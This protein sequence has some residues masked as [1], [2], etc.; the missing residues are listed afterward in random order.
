MVSENSLKKIAKKNELS[1]KFSGVCFSG[2]V[3]PEKVRT[4]VRTSSNKLRTK[5]EQTLNKVQ[6]NFKQSL[7]KLQTKFE[8]TLNFV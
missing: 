3:S 6:T 7:N 5:F 2:K 4:F 1:S 8:Q